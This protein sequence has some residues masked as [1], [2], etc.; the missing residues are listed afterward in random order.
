MND[1]D[2]KITDARVVAVRLSATESPYQGK[3]NS[4]F[5]PNRTGR[6]SPKQPDP[7]LE[8]V[9]VHIDS[10]AGVTGVGESQAGTGF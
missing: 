5:Q 1:D 6:R 4:Q 7:M 8:Y 3:D 10:D 9:P 2:T